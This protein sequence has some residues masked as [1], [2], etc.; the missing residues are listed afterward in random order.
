MR[1][2][3]GGPGMRRGPGGGDDALEITQ[4]Q[5][6]V[7]IRHADG[8]EETIATDGSTSKGEDRRG[9]ETSTS[10]S[11]TKGRLV[12]KRTLPARTITE[13]WETSADGAKLTETIEIHTEGS[14]KPVKIRRVFDQAKP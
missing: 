5:N 2:G 11:W 1:G 12:V 6:A 3:P 14:E 7:T 13:T 9:N 10:A 4:S 8:R